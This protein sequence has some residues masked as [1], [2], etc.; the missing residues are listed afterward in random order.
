MRGRTA[1]N[2]GPVLLLVG[3]PVALVRLAGWPLPTSTPTAQELSRWLEQPL[4]HATVTGTITLAA[5][6]IWLILAAAAATQL[7]QWVTRRYRMP[8]LAPPRPLQVLAAALLGTTAVSAAA[9]AAPAHGGTA[10]AAAGDRDLD[11]PA[12]ASPTPTGTSSTPRQP[13]TGPFVYE[14]ARGDWLGAVAERYLGDFD[15]YHDIRRLNPHL[16]PAPSGVDGP[17]HIH[18]GERYTLPPD[19]HD[20]GPQRHATGQ[21]LPSRPPAPVRPPS[22]PQRPATPGP[23]ITPSAAPTPTV[24]SGPASSTPAFTPPTSPGAATTDH[25]DP[26]PG[27]D[28]GDHG[29]VTVQLAAAVAAAAALV[30]IHRRRR[31]RPRPAGT[32]HRDDPDLAPLPRTV[33]ALHAS[34]RTST[35]ED[36]MDTI[37]Q[38]AFDATTVVTAS[39]GSHTSTLLHL[40]DLP[41]RGLGLTGPGADGA[42][43][44]LL[45]SVLSAGGA[46]APAT[47][48]TTADDLRRILPGHEHSTAQLER[49]HVADTIEHALDEL[50]R[51]LLHRAR[52]AE[53]ASDLTGV[54]VADESE[55]PPTVFLATAPTGGLVT[56]LTGTLAAG[57]QL[58]LFGVVLG[59]WPAGQ[60]WQVHADGTTTA[61]GHAGPRLNVLDTTATREILDTIQQARP[62]QDDSAAAPSQRSASADAVDASPARQAAPTPPIPDSPARDEPDGSAEP[63]RRVRLIVLGKPAVQVLDASQRNDLRI[64]R[65]DGVQILVHLAVNPDG[66]TSDELMA[67]LWP[68]IRPR[69]SRGR[70]HTTISELRRTLT[71]AIDADPIIRTDERYRLDPQRVEVDLWALHAALDSAATTVDPAEHAAALRKVVDL[72]T[73]TIAEGHHWLWL[74]PYQETTRRHVVDAYVHLADSASEA[75]Q[76]L[77]HIQS[78][79]RLDPYNEDL[80][81]HAMR[82]H[83]RLASPDGIRRTLRALAERLAE[84]ELQVSPHT[85]QV[86]TELVERLGIRERIQRDA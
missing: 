86:A 75:R 1:S 80:Y 25:A 22:R 50:E 78:A 19:A 72:Y 37:E 52:L 59:A 76:A 45:T 16:I 36:D 74:A 81:Q 5:W 13:A 53:E 20:R 34:A 38:Q 26:D 69:H 46:W 73:G 30:W 68:E 23:A 4:T 40:R 67:L 58:A 63:G 85:Q 48:I 64:R 42:A 24:S 15:R 57:A 10:T 65:S 27:V 2:L 3:I 77:A 41:A 49:L 66:A 18:P 79:I 14:V 12:P 21:L 83:G 47:V 44:G 55:P 35:T 56:R 11:R 62:A 51:H 29:W 70:F 31:Y 82:L 43:R 17:D 54:L 84:L 61:N 33:A 28:L 8:R 6:G 71:E 39:L 9:G 60:T 32:D 7:Y